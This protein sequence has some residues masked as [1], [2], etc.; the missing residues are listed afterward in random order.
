MFFTFPFQLITST[1]KSF[2][3]ED[4][5]D[6]LVKN[7]SGGNR[8]K[9]NVAVSCFG[10]TSIILM[11]EPTSDMDPVTRSL[12]YRAICELIAERRSVVLTSHTI[13]EIDRVCSRIAVLKDGKLITTGTPDYLKE[14]FGGYYNV[15]IF[16]D[17]IQ[18]LSMER[19]SLAQLQA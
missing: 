14:Q 10:D 18:A 2:N 17:K 12:V 19:V 7:L 13:S 16:Y 5:K 9:L 3:L 15:T 11:D 4:Y 8:R 1:L 6:V